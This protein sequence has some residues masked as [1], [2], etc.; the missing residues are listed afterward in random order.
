M[1]I[2]LEDIPAAFADVTG[3]TEASAQ[4][5]LSIVVLMA[6]VLPVMYLSKGKKGTTIEIVVMFL[7]L[8]MLVGIGWA[9]FWLLITAMLVMAVVVAMFG[10]DALTGGD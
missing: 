9:P 10:A 3:I 5:I 7:T 4:V 2:A 8:T 1:Q 6:F